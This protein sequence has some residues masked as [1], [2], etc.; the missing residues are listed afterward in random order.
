MLS[1]RRD[2]ITLRVS[3][4]SQLKT[5]LPVLAAIL[6]PVCTALANRYHHR[7]IRFYR[8][9]FLGWF[10]TC[11]TGMSPE[12][13]A[14]R[15]VLTNST[16]GKPES[17]LSTLDEWCGK[18]ECVTSTGPAKGQ[19]LESVVQR[20][21]PVR[22]LELGTN[23]GYSAIR[24]ARLL[25]PGAKL[26]TLEQ[27]PK[28]AEVAEEMMLVA[29]LKHTQFQVITGSL[30]EVIPRFKKWLGVE[31]FD[32]VFLNQGQGADYL[33]NLRL[34]EEERLLSKGSVI[35]ANCITCSGAAGFLSTVRG[36]P[37]YRTS[38]HPC[39]APYEKDIADGMEELVF[40][41]DDGKRN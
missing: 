36:D 21:G 6:V 8:H 39:P 11:L 28:T 18:Y 3:C 12:E 35:L 41:K 17:V 33:K 31:T 37:H 24:I 7:L 22:A 29:G 4:S 16:H 9:R 26:Y 10:K 40:L 14:F 38:F 27:D 2:L 19:I 20:S 23:C 1:F 34:L 25:T 15:Y 32:F 13:R 30:C 5:W